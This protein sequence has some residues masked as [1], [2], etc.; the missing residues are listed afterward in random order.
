MLN[1]VKSLFA[2]AAFAAAG[3]AVGASSA[4]AAPKPTPVTACPSPFA[5]T[6]ATAC[7]VGSGNNDKAELLNDIFGLGVDDWALAAKDESASASTG[8]TFDLDGFASAKSGSWSV[9]S[10][11]G[12]KYAALVVKGGSN[13]WL[14]YLL[15]TTVTS[16]SWS[17]LGILNGGG[18]QPDLSHLSLY[19]GGGQVAEPPSSVPL[20]AAIWML[21]AGLGGIAALSRKRA[22]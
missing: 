17:T 10:F 6:T 15:D 16:G 14:A 19:V 20:P 9:A 4:A 12:Y 11:D 5:V 8:G 22:A 21:L 1:T 2:A 13:G 18:N 3:V 7:A